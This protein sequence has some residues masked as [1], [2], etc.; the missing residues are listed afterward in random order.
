M[1]LPI[2]HRMKSH[3]FGGSIP[4]E[5]KDSSKLL[6]LSWKIIPGSLL[7]YHMALLIQ[8]QKVLPLHFYSI[9]LG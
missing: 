3:L 8:T 7:P 4:L 1:S 5:I 2:P 6:C 9:S